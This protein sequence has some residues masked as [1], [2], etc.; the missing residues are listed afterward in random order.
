VTTVPEIK[1]DELTAE[2]TKVVKDAVYISVGFGVLA[3]QKLQVQR[4]ELQKS[5]SGRVDAGKSHWDQ[6]GTNLQDQ[7]KSVEQR[8][9]EVEARIDEVLD[10]VQGKLPEQA[11]ELF[12]QA[13]TAVKSAREQVLEIVKREQAA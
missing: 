4:Q 6:L 2:L 7:L 10:Q 12:G 5:L 3:V 11:S 1:V 13:R 9:D 8:L